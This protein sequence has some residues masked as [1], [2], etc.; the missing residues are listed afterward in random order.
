M[1][2]QGAQPKSDAD[3]EMARYQAA[4]KAAGDAAANAAREQAY[5]D[6]GVPMNAEMTVSVETADASMLSVKKGEA[7]DKKSSAYRRCS[8]TAA[9]R[10]D[11]STRTTAGQIN[12][13]NS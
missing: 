4:R 9:H 12:S 1:S 3:E 7:P 2:E 6:A 8:S 13:R 10:D 5:R 11:Y